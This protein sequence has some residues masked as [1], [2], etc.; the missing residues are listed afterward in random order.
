MK[1]Q[2][3]RAQ[4]AKHRKRTA[5]WFTVKDGDGRLRGSG[6]LYD[7]AGW[8]RDMELEALDRRDCSFLK[9]THG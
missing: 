6:S 7:N 8:T 3:V 9:K 2:P 5:P 1:A 4:T